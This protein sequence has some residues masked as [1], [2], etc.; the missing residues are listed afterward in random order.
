MGRALAVA[1]YGGDA[2]LVDL[3]SDCRNDLSNGRVA[4]EIG[5]ICDEFD[6]VG[7]DICCNSW[8][9]ARRAPP[10]SPMPSALRSN[11][12][13]MGLPFLNE[14]D[15][16]LVD[17]HNFMYRRAI[18]YATRSIKAN[19]SGW[20]EN[21]LTSMLW[22]TKGIQKLLKLGARYVETHFCQYGCSYKKA[23]RFI[24]W[25]PKSGDVVLSR[26]SGKKGICSRTGK[27]HVELTG[28]HRGKFLTSAAQV[29][30][31]SL[32]RSFMSQLLG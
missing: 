2:A 3:A 30:P 19:K 27:R 16:N 5:N 26:C 1:E 9:R 29:Y 31:L 8:S 22:K 6:C 21:P 7:I 18:D 10:W 12:H 32:C 25:G 20:I 17:K 28:I 24:V 15:R 14:K 11:D 13:L 4:A 23:T